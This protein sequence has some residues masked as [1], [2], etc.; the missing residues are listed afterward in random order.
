MS[1]TAISAFQAGV[2]ITLVT[3][4]SFFLLIGTIGLLRLPT[5]YNR[6]HATSKA[7]T[8]GAAS[9]FLAGAVYF[10]PVTVAVPAVGVVPVLPQGKGLISLIGILFLFA[11]TPTGAHVISRSAQ[12]MG[13]PFLDGV[14]WPDTV[15][16]AIEDGEAED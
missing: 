3:V 10:D 9:L 16:E 11:T 12:A 5:V 4:G 7:T 13:V 6:M 15:D 1:E 8:L 14:R 2:V